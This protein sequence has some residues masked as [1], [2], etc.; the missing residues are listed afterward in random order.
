MILR[1]KGKERYH[2]EGGVLSCVGS[3]RL[4]RGH[5]TLL[6]WGIGKKKGGT[7]SCTFKEVA[8]KEGPRSVRTVECEL[9]N[10]N[11]GIKSA[12]S[13]GGRKEER[14]SRS[15]ADHHPSP[16]M[17]KGLCVGRGAEGGGAISSCHPDRIKNQ[18]QSL[19]FA[20]IKCPIFTKDGLCIVQRSV[21]PLDED[22]PRKAGL[23]EGY[24]GA[25][26][27]R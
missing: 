4:A 1:K 9:Y 24:R 17:L 12:P 3:P 13:L 26:A 18:K 8:S 7:F 11:T 5:P 10:R 19:R 25:G 21:G 2:Q 15:R 23:T 22:V 20:S 16:G 27:E 6:M 14:G